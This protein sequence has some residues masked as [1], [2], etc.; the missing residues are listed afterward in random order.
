MII[1]FRA[2]SNYL[3]WKLIRNC[4][5]KYIFCSTVIPDKLVWIRELKFLVQAVVY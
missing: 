3:K 4:Y 2:D 1:V 5:S